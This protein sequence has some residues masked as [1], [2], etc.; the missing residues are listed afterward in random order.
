MTAIAIRKN[1]EMP[2]TNEMQQFINIATVLSQCPY[3]AKMG[4]QG[5]LA[6]WL[7][8]RELGLPPMMCLNGGMYTFS[9]AVT[10]SA[11]LMN[12]MI[13]NA[14]HRADVL[15]L[16]EQGCKIRFVRSD[17]EKGQGD[18][19]EYEFTMQHAQQAGYFGVPGPN[20]SYIKK[21]KDNWLNSPRDM[22]YSRCL[23]GG[24][25]KFMPD[26]LMN[27][28]VIGEMPGDDEVQYAMP[29]LPVNTPRGIVSE[30]PAP[31]PAPAQLT[32]QS[33]PLPM[34]TEGYDEFVAKHELVQGSRKF[35]YIERVME[36]SAK[37]G[38]KR[39]IIDVINGAMKD[40][41]KF[42]DAFHNWLLKNTKPQEK[43]EI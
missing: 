38:R 22:F 20:G 34:K 27:C 28:Y 19:F 31:Q 32:E 24:S 39:D 26:V 7:T 37:S 36:A 43:N 2:T 11:Q 3:Y 29:A 33:K 35:Q 30:L 14:G 5:V 16:N 15:Y 17:R 8:A 13:V 40:E 10:L 1:Y 18:V 9:G 41:Q 6:I 21:P 25:R 4:P 12:M 42:L 23:S